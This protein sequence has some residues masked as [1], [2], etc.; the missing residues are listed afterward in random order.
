MSRAPSP[1]LT[2]CVYD[3]RSRTPQ[4]EG[5]EAFSQFH[6]YV[7]AAFLVKWSKQL[8]AHDFQGVI[9]FL[10]SPPTQDWSDREAE[11]LLSEAFM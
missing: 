5:P 8:L 7:C 3:R 9:I 4:A 10:Q 11:L 1:H 6:L 2:S